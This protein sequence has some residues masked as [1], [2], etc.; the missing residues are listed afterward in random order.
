MFRLFVQAEYVLV[1]WELQLVPTT[2]QNGVCR[3][4]IVALLILLIYFV[5][6]QLIG[7]VGH[8]VR[9]SRDVFVAVSFVFCREVYDVHYEALTKVCWSGL[10]IIVVE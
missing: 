1:L 7:K 9:I 3:R 6:R 5:F 4:F 2:P 10:D 8:V